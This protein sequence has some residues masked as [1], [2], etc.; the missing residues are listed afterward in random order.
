LI[1]REVRGIRHP[2][3]TLLIGY[4]RTSHTRS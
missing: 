4:S 2:C 3:H 1:I